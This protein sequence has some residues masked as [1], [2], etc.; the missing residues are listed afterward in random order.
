MPPGLVVL[1]SCDNK[2]CV[3]PAHL[4]AG[5]QAENVRDAVARGQIDVEALRARVPL[6]NEVRL[7]T[8]AIAR[9]VA[10]GEITHE[11]AVKIALEACR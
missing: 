7:R 1:H 10:R 9:R 3:N 11:A 2:A 8:L 4:S 5:T 6:M